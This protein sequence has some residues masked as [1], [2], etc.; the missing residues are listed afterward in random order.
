[1]CKIQAISIGE[2]IR[3]FQFHPEMSVFQMKALA[4]TRKKIF[5]DEKFVKNE[6]DFEA[7]KRSLTNTN[8]TGSQILKNFITYFVLPYH[9]K[10]KV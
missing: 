4:N 3:L 6:K 10:R 2:N 5:L 8:K 9:N 1:L 7:L